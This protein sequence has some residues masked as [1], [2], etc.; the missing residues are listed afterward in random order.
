MNE[1]IIKNQKHP[2]LLQGLRV[3]VFSVKMQQGSR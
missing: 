2:G 1:N 3:F